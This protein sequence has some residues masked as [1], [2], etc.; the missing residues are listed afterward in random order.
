MVLPSRVL[1]WEYYTGGGF[2][3]GHLPGGIADEALAMLW[4][5]LT[6]FRRW[7]A[8]HTVTVLDDR[9]GDYIPG[10]N[11]KTLPA[12][13]VC[14][15]T[16]ENQ[17]EVF[18]SLL[19]RC[20]AALIIA[21]ETDGILSRLS[22]EVESSEKTL[23]GSASS[24]VSLS[25]DKEVCGGVFEQANLSTP[26]TGITRVKHVEDV[27]KRHGLPLVLKPVDGVGSE[28]VCLIAD[29]EDIPGAVL[30]IRRVT[31]CDR[32][33]F[34]RYVE[35][36]HA[37][38][39]LL[40]AQGRSMPLSLNRQLIHP[41]IPFRY[42]GS[43]VPLEHPKAV[44]AVQTA[45]RAVEQ[46]HGLRGYVGVDM[47]LTGDSVCLIEVNPRLTTS[48][49]GLRQVLS[50][51]PARL[52]YEACVYGMLP[53]SIVLN[54]SVAVDCHDPATWGWEVETEQNPLSAQLQPEK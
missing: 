39:S 37:S 27:V 12:D 18:L 30:E 17:K 33:L 41:G 51:N 48:Y 52:I 36:T 21:P 20:D 46:I 1:V 23:L 44:D 19:Q 15:A 13:E 40:A 53:E 7:G 47:V 4:A 2:P 26:R 54:G 3:T 42:S 29:P 22:A 45:R 28:G 32:V 6:D 10:L 34:Q 50:S 11:R 8:V 31:A 5:V 9:F 43:V 14:C 35:G 24:A 49:I 16:P 38:V 25:G